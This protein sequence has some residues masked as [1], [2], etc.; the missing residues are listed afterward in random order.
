MLA[1]P[2]FLGDDHRGCDDATVA[3]GR[4]LTQVRVHPFNLSQLITQTRNPTAFCA[5]LAFYGDC[6]PSLQPV[7]RPPSLPRLALA[8]LWE[9]GGEER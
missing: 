1:F 3:V 7:A 4:R 2:L 6:P 8:S 9:A 5:V